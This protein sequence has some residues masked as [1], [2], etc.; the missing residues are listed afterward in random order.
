MG[1]VHAKG[2]RNEAQNQEGGRKE[3]RRLSLKSAKQEYNVESTNSFIVRYAGKT[4]RKRPGGEGIDIC[5][6]EVYS[7]ARKKVK[8]SPRVCLSITSREL[9][10]RE[11]ADTEKNETL[12]PFSRISFVVADKKNQ[13][14]AFND[15]VSQRPRRIE[16]HVFICNDTES[17]ETIAAALQGAFGT[18]YSGSNRKMS[19]TEK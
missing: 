3:P 6:R 9:V 14:F 8:E 5:L 1:T 7:K 18:H 15:F 11:L 16:C 17:S 12:I 19:R 10:I 4:E 2:T 13:L